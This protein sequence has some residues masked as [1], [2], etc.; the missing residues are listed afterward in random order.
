ME[1]FFLDDDESVLGYHN[2]LTKRA[3][4]NAEITM[5]NDGRT[6]LGE[7]LK[8]KNNEEPFPDFVFIDIEMPDLDGFDV[9]KILKTEGEN[10]GNVKLF[11]LTVRE[12]IEIEEKLNTFE[13]VEFISKPLTTEKL[14]ALKLAY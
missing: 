9:L 12:L 14:N 5:F 8:R 2:A 7:I 3:Y 1:I 11:I 13:N 4:P 10:V 6:L